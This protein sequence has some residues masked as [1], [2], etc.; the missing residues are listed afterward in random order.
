MPLILFLVSTP[1]PT[2]GGAI[3]VYSEAGPAI[4]KTAQVVVRAA[5]AKSLKA[6]PKAT[7]DGFSEAPNR[8]D[9][10]SPKF[11]PPKFDPKE[12]N[13]LWNKK[14]SFVRQPPMHRGTGDSANLGK[15]HNSISQMGC[16]L[17]G[18]LERGSIPY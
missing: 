16:A 1:C 9:Q 7:L 2:G 13:Q 3:F 14:K 12:T 17:L 5:P 6:L 15:Q 18:S 4:N 10:V 11:D 8:S